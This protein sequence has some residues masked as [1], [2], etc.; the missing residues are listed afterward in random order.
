MTRTNNSEFQILAKQRGQV[1]F[2]RH[3]HVKMLSSME[4]S[5]EEVPWRQ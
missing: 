4:L 3:V 1:A 2:P 5:R